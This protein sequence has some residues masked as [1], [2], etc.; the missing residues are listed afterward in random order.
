LLD[1]FSIADLTIQPDGLPLD[2]ERICQ[3]TWMCTPPPLGPDIHANTTGYGVIARAF[4]DQLPS[5][6]PA[7]DKKEQP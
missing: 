4:A 7:S 6:I 1:A 3:W 2:V 5:F